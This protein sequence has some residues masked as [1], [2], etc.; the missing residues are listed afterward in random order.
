MRRVFH[1]VILRSS[2]S[3]LATTIS[4]RWRN[5]VS[6]NICSTGGCGSSNRKATTLPGFLSFGARFNES[7]FLDNDVG[8]DDRAVADIHVVT[9][10]T[11]CMQFGGRRD[12]CVQP[13][14]HPKFDDPKPNPV[15]RRR[16]WQPIDAGG[17]PIGIAGEQR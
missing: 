6:S 2:I 16:M 4:N 9:D 13:G 14:P 3:L 8:A 15:G 11:W 12:P 10:P 17:E 5:C 7:A 1:A